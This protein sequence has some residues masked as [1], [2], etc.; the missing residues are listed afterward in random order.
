MAVVVIAVLA[1]VG[2]QVLRRAASHQAER[3][4][5]QESHPAESAAA[6]PVAVAAGA[7]SPPGAGATL[8]TSLAPAVPA[9]SAAPS[10]IAAPTAA[11]AAGGVA[12]ASIG[13]GAMA[14]DASNAAHRAP[15]NA[16]LIEFSRCLAKKQ[17]SMYGAYWCPH[18]AEQKEKFGP[19]FKYVPYVECAVLGQP[20]NVQSDAC[21]DMQ[22]HRYPTWIFP[23][24]DRVE[25][26]QTLEQLG[27]RTGCKL[28]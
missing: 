23:D 2:V 10:A 19:A 21:R 8:S 11:S 3:S 18:C 15:S 24:G 16:S 14:S 7:A 28:P 13:S 22:I 1:V 4:S 9:P 6:T 5:S 12:R 27:Q 25:A 17:V 26:I 20:T